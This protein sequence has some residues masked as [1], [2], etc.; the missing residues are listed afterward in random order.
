MT[1]RQ[2][3]LESVDTLLRPIS[4]H[5]DYTFEQL[6]RE[7]NY[8][9]TSDWVRLY[10]RL[11]LKETRMLPRPRRALD[12]GCGVGI[13]RRVEFLRAVREQVDELWGIEPDPTVQDT[14]GDF[15]HFQNAAMETAKLPD[16]Y[17]NF[18]F[19]FMVMEHVA[20]P[21]RYLRAVHQ[22]LAPGGVHFF[23][24]VNARHY[25]TR[26]ASLLRKL[27][28][29]EVMLRVLRGSKEVD[30]YH[31]PVQYRCNDEETIT[32]LAR[33]Q[34]FDT[35][36]FAYVEEDGPKPYFP[37]PIRPIWWTLAKKREF[38]RDPKDLLT[39]ICRM[40]KSQS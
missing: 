1:K 33:A 9:T 24:T 14:E 10:V 19:S 38:I 15:T 36:Q 17:F 4:P 31:Y 21:E 11:L 29:D 28:A 23:I 2:Q 37:L 30:E 34:G 5:D 22:A 12:I 7:Y 16:N 25:F 13:G 39:L 35:P 32:R 18:A 3:V 20:D 26:C 8:R 40:R 6:A 27:R